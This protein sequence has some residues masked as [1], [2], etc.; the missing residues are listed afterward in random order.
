VLPNNLRGLLGPVLKAVDV[1][2]SH[3]SSDLTTNTLFSPFDALANRRHENETWIFLRDPRDCKDEAGDPADLEAVKKSVSE[4]GCLESVEGTSLY[5]LVAVT[6][7]APAPVPMPVPV[8][9]VLSSPP[10]FVLPRIL[11]ILFY[12]IL[13]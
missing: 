9:S 11:A 13:V 7:L 2:T 10:L 1:N 12:C 8:S 3:A 4:G 6:A 5:V